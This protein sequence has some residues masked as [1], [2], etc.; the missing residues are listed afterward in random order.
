MTGFQKLLCL[1]LERQPAAEVLQGTVAAWV[2]TLTSRLAWE[3]RRDAARIRKAFVTMAGTRRTWP[4]PADLIDAMPRASDSGQDAITF[5]SGVPTTRE[6][7]EA[8]LERLRQLYGDISKES[9]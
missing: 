1:G 4:Q 6:E 2:E 5:Q 8:N 9:P 3:E 7:R